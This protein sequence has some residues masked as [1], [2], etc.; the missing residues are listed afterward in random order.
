VLVCVLL[1]GLLGCGCSK[2]DPKK[3][4][5]APLL[6]KVTDAE[7]HTLYLFGTIHVGD[8]RSDAVLPRVA[9]VLDQCDALAV[10]FDVIAFQQDAGAVMGMMGQYVLTDG[11]TVDAH[12]PEDL[13]RR[14]YALLEEAGL[15]PEMMKNYDLAMWAQLVETAAIATRS[16]LSAD[17]A[18]DVMIMNYAYEKQ[19]PVLEVESAAFQM[20]LLNSFD[21][22]TYLLQIRATL[23]SLEQYGAAIEL[24]YSLWLSGDRDTFWMAIGAEPALEGADAYNTAL[25]DDRNRTMAE[26]ATEYLA[27]GRTVFFAVGAA[28]MANETGIVQLLID[29]GYTVEEIRY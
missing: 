4:E 7:G 13:Y 6:W 17:K 15:M 10:E 26:K 1:L 11:T 20:D 8:E 23:D 22:E 14:A 3:T 19:I 18:M 12:M 28:H 29:A 2:D 27:S 21:D 9:K 16:G 5:N 24:L 25:V